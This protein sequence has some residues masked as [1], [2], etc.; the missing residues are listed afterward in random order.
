[1]FS[2]WKG[3]DRATEETKEVNVVLIQVWQTAENTL[4][5]IMLII[6]IEDKTPATAS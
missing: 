3:K 6:T 5:S 4:N 2:F 1:M